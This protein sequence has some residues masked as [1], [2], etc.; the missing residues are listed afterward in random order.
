[1]LRKATTLA[2][3]SLVA[4]LAAPLPVEAQLGGLRR[5]A[6]RAVENEVNKKVTTVVGE[7]TA[8]AIGNRECVDE[9]RRRD[10]KVV[11]V[12][13][14]GKVIT[15]EA[16]NPVTDPASAEATLEGPGQGR[17]ANYDY[18]R[19]GRPIFNTRWNVEDTENPP[20][21]RPNPAVRVGRIPG[22]IEFVQGNIQ[23]I[24]LEGMNTAEFTTETVF[25]VPLSEPLTEDFSLEFTVDLALPNA[26]VYVYF[27][28]F[29]ELGVT[30][31]QYERHYL[32]LYRAGGIYQHFERVSGT[33]QMWSLSNQLTPVKFQVD[34]GYAILYVDGERVAQVP[35]FVHAVGSSVIEFEVNANQNNPA[36]IRDIRVDY[37]VDDPYEAFA[38]SGEYTTRSIY[39]DFNSSK[40]R[41][42]STPELE[43]IRGMLEQYG[44]PVIIEGHTDA[45]GADD[46]NLRLSQE[47]AEAVRSY[48]VGKG[49][50][51][52]R[53]EAVGKGEAE[54]IADNETDDGRQLNRRVLVR[55][56]AG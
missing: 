44:Q 53:I 48:L 10:E 29:A 39:F 23:I 56:A 2:L 51:A 27:E 24:Q 7:A 11:I 37:G 31:R 20:A 55:A 25:R 6:Q 18:L 34:D 41:P 13:D 36:Y 17:W 33:D 4:G 45:V 5:A 50:A 46:V 1:M 16:G 30:T 42:E 12:D 26:F 54:P 21:L 8:C 35:N 47:R 3:L 38:E 19:G 52:G 32:N 22:N 28:P 9:A 43:R 40:L 15:D 14:D 49:V